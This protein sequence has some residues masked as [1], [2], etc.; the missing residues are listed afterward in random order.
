MD[1]LN[2]DGNTIG[3]LGALLAIA[4]A[5]VVVGRVCGRDGMRPV[6]QAASGHCCFFSQAVTLKPAAKAPAKP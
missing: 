1:K 4:V 2:A 3:R 5:V 6:A